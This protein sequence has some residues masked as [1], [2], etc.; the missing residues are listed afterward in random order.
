MLAPD[1]TVIKTPKGRR[2]DKKSPRTRKI[3]GRTAL[4][5]RLGDKKRAQ[6]LARLKGQELADMIVFLG[7][8]EPSCLKAADT[9]DSGGVDLTDAVGIFEF[10]FS[11][12]PPPVGADTGCGVDTTVDG[13]SCEEVTNCS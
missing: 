7:E 3:L 12:G 8:R 5:A 9:N 10:L 1:F 2:P 4:L 13:L 6:E 11:G